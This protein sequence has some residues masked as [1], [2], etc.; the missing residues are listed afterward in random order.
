MYDSL[1]LDSLHG[2]KATSFL[3]FFLSSVQ[4]GFDEG[5]RIDLKTNTSLRIFDLSFHSFQ[6]FANLNDIFGMMFHVVFKAAGNVNQR[7][8]VHFL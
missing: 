5:M 2:G 3:F 4:L 6:V 1:D 7:L 8:Q